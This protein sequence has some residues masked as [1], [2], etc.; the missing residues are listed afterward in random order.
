MK[1]QWQKQMDDAFENYFAVSATLQ[2]D[3]TALLHEDLL[4]QS[5]RRNFIRAASAL[6]EEYAHCFRDL[7]QVGIDSGSGLL[8]KKEFQVLQN[9]KGFD[10]PERFKLT[11]RA[12]FKLFELSSVP[13]FGGSS[14]EKMKLLLDRRNRVMHPKSAQDLEISD[15]HWT[16]IHEGAVWGFT[17]LFSFIEKLACEHGTIQKR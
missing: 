11:L 6:M 14:W 9:E 15:E 10:S 13:D 17:Q 5:S 4:G 7:C 3:V 8:S 2:A 12:T 1:E 16:L